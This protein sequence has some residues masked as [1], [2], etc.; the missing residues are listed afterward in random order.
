[1]TWYDRIIVGAAVV[2]ALYVIWNKL[3]RPVINIIK[4]VE[5]FYPVI[6]IVTSIANEFKEN[7]GSTLKDDVITLKSDVAQLR[8]GFEGFQDYVHSELEALK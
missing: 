2:G 6:A 7:S 3:I 1:M 8:R 5:D 4:A